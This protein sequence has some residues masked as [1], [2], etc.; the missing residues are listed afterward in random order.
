MAIK[1]QYLKTKPECKVTFEIP[2]EIAEK[3]QKASLVGDFN[4]WD[5]N[6]TPM[7][8]RRKDNA[9]YVTMNLLKD[10]EY[11]FRYLL[12]GETWINDED[13]DKHVATYY[14]DAENSVISL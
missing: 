6:A 8:R 11:Q 14:P 3:F 12:D 9:F 4:N 13:A 5:P 1:K 2:K 10:A 7:K